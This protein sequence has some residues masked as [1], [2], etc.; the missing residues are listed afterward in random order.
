[1]VGET[2]LNKMLKSMS[3]VLSAV[4]Y[5]FLS[6]KDAGY[7]DYAELEPIVSVAEAE[8]LTLVVEKRMAIEQS[9]T[10]ESSYKRITLMVHSSLEAVGLTAAFSAKLTEHNISANVIAGYFHDHIFVQSSEADR[11]LIALKELSR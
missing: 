6:F 1:M 8:G 4:D 5:V 7:G 9:L 10:F 2:D 11:A 3:P